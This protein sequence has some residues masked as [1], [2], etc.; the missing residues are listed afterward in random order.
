MPSSRQQSGDGGPR[1]AARAN[2][3]PPDSSCR[4]GREIPLRSYAALHGEGAV[5]DRLLTRVLYG[6]SCRNYAAAAEAIP[7]AIGLSGSTVSRTFIQASAAKLHEF[8]ERDLSNE[9][10]VAIVL[11]GKTFAEATGD[12]DCARASHDGRE[13]LPGL[14]R[15]RHGERAGVD[16]VLA[17]LLERGLDISQGVLVILVRKAFRARPT[18]QWHKRETWSVAKTEQPHVAARLQRA[19]HRPE[20]DEAW[21]Q[22]AAGRVGGSESIGGPQ[23]D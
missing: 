10:V 8:H 18:V 11:D 23:S 15:N 6:I 1:G 22:A 2:S 5:N 9:N 3:C 12:G 4:G 16:A 19:Y 14:R 17:S 13:T 20:Y 7:G 21:L